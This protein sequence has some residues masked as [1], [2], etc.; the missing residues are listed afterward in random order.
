MGLAI[1][2]FNSLKLNVLLIIINGIRNK[3]I[4]AYDLILGKTWP[5]MIPF[6]CK[7][8]RKYISTITG[9]LNKK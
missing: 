5:R 7:N 9:F 2:F 3:N 6:T 8:N 4:V 1:V